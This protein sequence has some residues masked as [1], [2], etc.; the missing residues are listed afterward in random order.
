MLEFTSF[1]ITYLNQLNP[2]TSFFTPR[3]H[4]NLKL[5][6]PSFPFFDQL[7][8]PRVYKLFLGRIAQKPSTDIWWRPEFAGL[9]CGDAIE[10]R[11][12]KSLLLKEHQM[13]VG[14][15]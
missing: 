5:C 14:W 12:P 10:S 7:T 1:N 11:V 15:K 8:T 4:D 2:S 6:A 9:E 3:L 13:F